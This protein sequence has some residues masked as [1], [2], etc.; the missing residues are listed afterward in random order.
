MNYAVKKLFLSS[1]SKFSLLTSLEYKAFEN[2]SLDS[3]KYLRTEV[4]VLEVSKILHSE[5]ALNFKIQLFPRR[6]V[7]LFT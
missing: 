3:Y 5:F 1:C 4:P 6:I 7:V 2:E